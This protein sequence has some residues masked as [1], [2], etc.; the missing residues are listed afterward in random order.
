MANLL[1]GKIYYPLRLTELGNDRSMTYAVMSGTNGADGNPEPDG[2]C[3][4]WTS[5]TGSVYCGTATETTLS[6]SFEF[7]I[8]GDSC[9]MELLPIYCFENDS[10]MGA[11]PAPVMPAGGRRA[12]VSSTTWTPGGG[13][14]AADAVCQGDASAAGLANA[15]NFRALLTTTVAATDSSRISLSGQPWYRLDGAQLV[16]AAADLGD[17]GGNKMLTSLNLTPAREYLPLDSAWTGSGVAAA[18]TAMTMNCNNWTSS[19][20][21]LM[22]FWGAVNDS[23]TSWWIGN[24]NQPC[25]T[26]DHLYCFER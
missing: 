13:V 21:T 25:G 11:V 1:A 15:A 23:S 26:P 9:G 16:A 14:A 8:G 6:W 18:S 2:T 20:A 19:S 3:G 24:N 4:D 12:F 5:S 10:G 7:V 17:P 22:S